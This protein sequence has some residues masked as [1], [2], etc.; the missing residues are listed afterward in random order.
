MR[1][2]KSLLAALAAT[3]ALGSCTDFANGFDEKRHEFAENF[4]NEFG[5]IN[6]DQ[7]WNMAA[8]YS[9]SINLGNDVNGELK[10]YS[11]APGVKGSQYLGH[12]EV[13]N[14]V[15]TL[16]FDAV[17]GSKYFYAA[18]KN[19][20]GRVVSLGYYIPNGNKVEIADEHLATRATSSPVTKGEKVDL[21]VERIKEGAIEDFLEYYGDGSNKKKNYYKMCQDLIVKDEQGYDVAKWDIYGQGGEENHLMYKKQTEDGTLIPNLYR[22]NNVDFTHHDAGYTGKFLKTIFGDFTDVNGNNAE[23]IYK[24][25]IDH[26]ALMHQ[27]VKD[28]KPD[29]L[30]TVAEGGGEVELDCIWR[31][32]QGT[33]DFFGYYYYDGNMYPN[34]LTAEELW[35]IDKYI[36][37]D[38]KGA[39]SSGVFIGGAGPENATTLTEARYYQGNELISE[40]KPTDGMECASHMN[41]NENNLIRGTKIKLTNFDGSTPSYHFNENTKI[42]FFFGWN[43]VTGATTEVG[44]Y[45]NRIFFSDC[46]KTYQLFRRTYFP[47]EDKKSSMTT[48]LLPASFLSSHD[49][50]DGSAYEGPDV[51]PFANTFKYRDLVILGFGDEV[52][53][54]KD[55]NDI[56]FIVNGH[57]DEPEDITPDNIPEPEAASWLMACEDLGNTDD[58]DFNDVVFK[59]SHVANETKAKITALASGGTLPVELTYNGE[60][61][62]GPNNSKTH[63]NSWFDDGRIED[64]QAINAGAGTVQATGKSIEIPVPMDFSLANASV[65]DGRMGGFALKVYDRKD[66]DF[67]TIAAPNDG[68]AP[69]MMCLPSNWVWPN[70]RTRITEAYPLFGEWGSNYNVT[71]WYM[72]YDASNLVKTPDYTSI[73]AEDVTTGGG[74]G[75]GEGTGTGSGDGGNTGGDSDTKTVLVVGTE[76]NLT[77]TSEDSWENGGYKYIYNMSNYK[78]PINFSGTAVLTIETDGG[79]V[80][81]MHICYGDTPASDWSNHLAQGIDG[82][83]KQTI[84]ITKDN[85]DA[86]LENGKMLLYYNNY[87]ANGAKVK[88]VTLV[89]SND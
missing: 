50:N 12:V 83:A 61:L 47:N 85:M 79:T 23:G 77:P 72:H 4:A 20:K 63:F 65:S 58:F 59:V 32:T 76:Y 52:A 56:C 37:I 18:V 25:G 3:L 1:I 27:A 17:K 45:A 88:S 49:L 26:V 87:Y 82:A 21:R 24:E 43:K 15:A 33:Y 9:A 81:A 35:N 74:S 68:E 54:D 89:L 34:G 40:W 22:L 28:V 84:S 42:G 31:G 2:K 73:P 44:P 62:T 66:G 80:N 86:I 8:R 10:L 67:T 55:L 78:L 57:I 39:G 14:G 48:D 38:E 70:E 46:A 53:G 7:D 60:V 64:G 16:D 36:L 75:S 29:V 19:T 41:N 11:D 69:Q 13:V 6:P 71:N 5:A 30:Y 51:R